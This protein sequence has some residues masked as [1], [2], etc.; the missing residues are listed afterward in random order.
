MIKSMLTV[1]FLMSVLLAAN[2]PILPDSILTPG[3]TFANVNMKICF[4]HYTDSVRNVSEKMKKKVY[5][6]YNITKHRR[7]E[8]EIDHLISLELGGN[9]DISNLWPQSYLT[10]VWNARKKD[11]LE[12]RLKKLICEGNITIY[13]AQYDIS[14][15]WIKAYRKYMSDSTITA[16]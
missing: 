6:L 14:H 3:D 8:Y 13:Q 11:V 15:N 2:P 12:N 16:K 7:G 4:P 5:S 10:P 9:N 1:L